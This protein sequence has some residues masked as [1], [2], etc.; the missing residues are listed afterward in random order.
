MKKLNIKINKL[1]I[2]DSLN[3][4]N[5]NSNNEEIN[6]KEMANEI[7]KKQKLKQNNKRKYD[8]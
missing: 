2:I 5:A 3:K 4:I 6:I 1:D 7:Y 8:F